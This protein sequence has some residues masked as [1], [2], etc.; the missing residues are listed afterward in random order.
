MNVS[1]DILVLS[2]IYVFMTI[3]A[4]TTDDSFLNILVST[5]IVYIFR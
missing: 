5:T 2:K 3:K 1:K 4:I